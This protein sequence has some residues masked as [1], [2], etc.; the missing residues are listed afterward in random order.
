MAATPIRGLIPTLSTFIQSSGSE[1][2]VNSR[3]KWDIKAQ[4][5]GFDKMGFDKED[6]EWFRNDFWETHTSCERP[7]ELKAIYFLATRTQ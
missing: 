4:L 6:Q 1:E 5:I 7:N 3:M 2:Y